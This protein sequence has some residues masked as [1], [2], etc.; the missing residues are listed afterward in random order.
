MACG[1]VAAAAWEGRER[2]MTQRP[3]S[4]HPARLLL[5]KPTPPLPLL[6]RLL[7]PLLMPPLPKV[8]DKVL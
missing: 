5:M 6:P 2:G 8:L 3:Q 4:G 1:G 7:R